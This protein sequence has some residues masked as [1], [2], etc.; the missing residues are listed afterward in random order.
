MKIY[1]APM[2]GLADH[3]LR[4]IIAH[5]GGYDLVITEFVRVVDQL[6]PPSVFYRIVPELNQHALTGV[7]T[8]VRVQL[9][10]NHADALARNALR[11][12]ELGSHGIDLNF[13]CPSKTVN[14]SLGGA[15]LLNEPETLYRIVKA[16]RQA[17]PEEHAVSAKM[18]LGYEDSSQMIECASALASAGADEITVH[19]RT[20]VQGYAPPA[21]WHLVE[22]ISNRV[23]TPLIINGDIWC[24]DTAR[25]ALK[26]SG[27]QHL[28]IGRGAVRNPWL[29]QQIK[30]THSG[31]TDW[32]DLH[33]IIM[34]FW[35]AVTDQ[36]SH[37]YCSGRLKQW[38]KH[39][40]E[41]NPRAA[42]L[43]LEL[44]PLTDVAEITELLTGYRN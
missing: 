12:I 23:S 28:M 30:G 17:V 25:Q 19:A 14:N 9:L 33:A 44:R 6:L 29:A 40:K 31:S 4:N 21:H 10:G 38:L 37:R 36:M 20:K 2:E 39:L 42:D 27:C 32:T 16:V 8:P 3:F 35:Q 24:D 1:L 11:A 26:A 15:I 22:E 5:R 41:S 13:G 34:E 7:D 18:R 43:Y